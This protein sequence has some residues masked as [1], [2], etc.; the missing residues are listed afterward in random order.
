MNN[1]YQAP[2]AA[3]PVASSSGH[4]ALI[5]IGVACAALTAL[6]PTLVMPS[7]SEMFRSF[8]ATLPW[9]TQLLVQGYGALW[10]LPV[11][12]LLIWGA[13]PWPRSRAKAACWFGA[14][15]LILGL[16]A[17]VVAMYLPIFALSQ[18]I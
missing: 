13:W 10:I 12:V 14:F 7:F 5:V 18:T 4:P 9:P 11:L 1:P 2:S 6:V 17:C 8:G 3:A 15:C 16:P